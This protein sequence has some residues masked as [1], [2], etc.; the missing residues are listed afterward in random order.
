MT[1]A[2]ERSNAMHLSFNYRYE[3]FVVTYV[4]VYYVSTVLYCLKS[5]L[6]TIYFLFKYVTSS[7]KRDLI[8]EETVSSQ[9]SFFYTFAI[10][11]FIKT[12]QGARKMFPLDAH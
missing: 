11:F 1:I 3:R 12:A 8:A 4:L 5:T 9:I 6:T 10:V 7:A 2:I